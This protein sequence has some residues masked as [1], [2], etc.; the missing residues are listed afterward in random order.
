MNFRILSTSASYP[1]G[2]VVGFVFA[3]RKAA[4]QTLGL[5]VLA[6]GFFGLVR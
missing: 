6:G 4:V 3:G 2:K 5:P 1:K